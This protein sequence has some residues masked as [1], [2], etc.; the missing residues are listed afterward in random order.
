[1]AQSM[2]KSAVA[3]LLISVL[4]LGLLT[5]Q[6]VHAQSAGVPYMMSDLQSD[7]SKKMF[8]SLI[9]FVLLREQDLKGSWILVRERRS[10]RRF[11]LEVVRDNSLIFTFS[12]PLARASISVSAAEL[13]EEVFR[14]IKKE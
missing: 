14:V 5:A 4:V 11:I 13:A 12:V 10:G 7:Y 2:T 9:Q 1:M 3:S 6:P 8:R